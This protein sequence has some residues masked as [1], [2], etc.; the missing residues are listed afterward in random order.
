MSIISEAYEE[1]THLNP[2][3]PVR[4]DYAVK[5]FSFPPHYHR[6]IEIL[7]VT[8]GHMPVE[9]NGQTY[10]LGKGDLMFIGSHH[11]HS[12]SQN[13]DKSATSYY[14]LILDWQYLKDLSGNSTHYDFLSPVLLKTSLIHTL[15]DAKLMA[16]VDSVLR[17]VNQ[18]HNHGGSGSELMVLSGLY[19]LLSLGA[20]YL[21]HHQEDSPD[22]KQLQKSYDIMQRINGLIFNNY[23][24]VITLEEAAL[25]AG[26]SPYHFTRVFKSITGTTFKAY[27]TD[28][29]LRMVKDA[30]RST[31]LPITDLALSHGFNSLKTFNRN[32]LSATGMTPTDYRKSNF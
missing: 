30:L 6:G 28:F 7:F 5:S 21:E 11:I 22:R 26:Y 12:Y 4:C 27:L 3:Y 32:F 16:Q 23:T 15:A 24:R 20:R 18:E 19:R 14:M 31:D 9:V 1:Q 13:K 25:S 2:D 17:T 29:R 10:T 8:D